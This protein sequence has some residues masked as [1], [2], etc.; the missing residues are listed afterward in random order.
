MARFDQAIEIEAPAES[1]WSVL[2]DAGQWQLWF[3][4]VETVSNLGAV[5]PGSTFQWQSAGKTGTGRIVRATPNE[6]LEVSTEIGGN[7]ASHTF[8]VNRSGGLLSGGKDT[9]LQYTF[10][11]RTAGGLVGEFVAGGNPADLT[12]VKNT[13]NKVKGLAERAAGGK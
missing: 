3:P 10:E 1:V 12:K 2:T 9:R 6:I 8:Q 4:D 13:V 11:Y 7:Q 5:Q